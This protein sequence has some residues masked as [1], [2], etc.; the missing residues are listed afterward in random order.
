MDK[1]EKLYSIIEYSKDTRVTLGKDV[2]RQV[3]ELE[4][5][6][7]K[8][9]IL[10]ALSK[11]IAPRLEPIKRDVVLVVEYHPGE[12]ISVALSRKAKISEIIDAKTLTPKNST[13][14]KSEVASSV[15]QNIE[16]TKHI[17]NPTKG[18]RV[19]FPDGS[20]VWNRRAIDTFINVLRKIGLERIPEVGLEHG[21]YNLVSKQMRPIEPG[22]IWQHE[23]DGWYVYSNISNT[24][25]IDDL[26]RISDYYKLGLKIEEGKPDK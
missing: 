6:I 18:L 26:T 14:V 15:P 23:C 8:D 1:L 25:K 11:D 21:G 4:E 12:P 10:P 5:K 13:P 7:I 16:P 9:E 2:L 3:E 22:R 17:E 24:Q 19:V 20:V